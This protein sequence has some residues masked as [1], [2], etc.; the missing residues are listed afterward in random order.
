M[1]DGDF[2]VRVQSAL[3]GVPNSRLFS[4]L[5]ERNSMAQAANP[6]E[7]ACSADRDTG[8]P[9]RRERDR[10]SKLTRI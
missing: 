8:E 6:S 4:R 9:E 3:A 1:S 10:L 2:S 5:M 7:P